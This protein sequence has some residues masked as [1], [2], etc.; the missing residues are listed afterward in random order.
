MK[1]IAV[2][3]DDGT[4][5]AP[6]FGRSASFIVFEIEDGKITRKEVRT[7]NQGGAQ[8]GEC[9]GADSHDHSHGHGHNHTTM[10]EI[11]QDCE[12]ILCLGMG[13]RAAEALKTFGIEPLMIQTDLPAQQ[14]VEAYLAGTL[15]TS[16]GFCCCHH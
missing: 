11:L 15:P 8:H 1:R 3:S 7:N 10:G 4:Y 14:A 16:T 13:W 2:P 9:H 12:T 5:I 6:H